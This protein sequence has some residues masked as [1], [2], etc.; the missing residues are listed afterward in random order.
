M[1]VA[2]F[3]VAYV[4]AVVAFLVVVGVV[5]FAWVEML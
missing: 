4:F 2:S 1:V 5:V 3:D